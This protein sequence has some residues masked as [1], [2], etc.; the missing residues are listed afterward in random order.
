MKKRKKTL[1]RRRRGGLHSPT[2]QTGPTSFRQMPGEPPPPSAMRFE[3]LPRPIQPTAD[4]QHGLGF[5]GTTSVVLPDNGGYLMT[6]IVRWAAPHQ[7][8][9]P[10]V[11]LPARAIA[12]ADGVGSIVGCN[13]SSV[14]VYHSTDGVKWTFLSTLADTHDY[15]QSHE[16]PNE[17]DVTVLPD[18][19]TLLAV[20][21][22]C[23]F[24]FILFFLSCFL[25]DAGV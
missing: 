1:R 3:G 6:A 22:F 11:V 16:G 12:T 24:C 18:G 15:P 23:L 9:C 17:H 21:R 14:V 8:R 2:S 20:V 19:K 5:G 10:T 25:L 13:R 4:G 7:P